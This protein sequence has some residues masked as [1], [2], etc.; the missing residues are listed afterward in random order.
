MAVVS[1][2]VTS[3]LNYLFLFLQCDFI[4]CC[5]T[6]AKQIAHHNTIGK[7]NMNGNGDELHLPNNE[8]MKN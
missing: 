6:N 8:S 1:F 3:P 4:Y 5:V 2:R 7:F